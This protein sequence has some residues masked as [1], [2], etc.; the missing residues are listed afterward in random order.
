MYWL[1]FY[2]QKRTEDQKSKDSKQLFKPEPALSL[3]T[4]DQNVYSAVLSQYYNCKEQN[5]SW[6]AD[7]RSAGQ[8]TSCFVEYRA[9]IGL[10]LGTIQ[11]QLN[12]LQ[13]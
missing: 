6:E 4:A 1:R 10:R 12:P 3:L 8:E 2:V 11:T 13:P 5:P 9:H 7:K